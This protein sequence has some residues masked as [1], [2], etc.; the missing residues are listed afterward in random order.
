MA[1]V[2]L[3]PGLLAYVQ[4]ISKTDLMAR[5]EL[6]VTWSKSSAASPWIK[7]SLVPSV[8]EF[9]ER[10]DLI[11]AHEP[12]KRLLE[13]TGLRNVYSP[14]DMIRPVYNLLEKALPTVYC[15]ISDELHKDFT[16]NPS[17]PWHG[18]DPAIEEL[19]QRALV[20]SHVEGQIHVQN[21]LKLFASVLGTDSVKFTAQ[22]QAVDPETTSGFGLSEM[23]KYVEDQFQHVR[24][25]EDVCSAIAPIDIWAHAS[26]ASDIK[27][28][29]Q[30]ACRSRMIAI[31]TYAGL[32]SVPPFF[33]GA[34]FLVSLRKWQA[35]ERHRFAGQT[36]ESCAAAVLDLPTIKIKYFR[37]AKR[38]LDRAIPLRAH[39]S[40]SGVGLRLMMWQRP[41]AIRCI[42]FANVGGK[43]EEE[44]SYSDPSRSV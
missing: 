20:M 29:V 27:F 3:D 39:I 19:S 15:C 36:L 14:E 16:S 18:N 12:A 2:V 6:L 17:Q 40:K 32:E 8:R 28:A 24:S 37:K 4:T 41:T 25:I 7:L 11:P 38:S 43:S 26:S 44:I 33:V 31:G 10:H 21:G 9:L 42:E 22:L 23:P 5:I 30:L 35:D 1:T 34:E 13:N